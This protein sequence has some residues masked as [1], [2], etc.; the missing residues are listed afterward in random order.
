MGVQR[1]ATSRNAQAETFVEF[2]LEQFCNDLELKGII[3]D[4]IEK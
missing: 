4:P 3:R 1:F 2:V